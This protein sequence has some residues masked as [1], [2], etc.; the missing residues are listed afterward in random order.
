MKVTGSFAMKTLTSVTK[1]LKM[2]SRACLTGLLLT[3]TSLSVSAGTITGSKHDFSVSGFT[4]GEICIACH[5]P[6]NADATVS[7]A[8]LWNHAL[9]TATYSL[10]DSPTMDATDNNQQPTGTSKLCLSCHD[11]TVALDSSAD[12]ITMTGVAAVGADGLSNDHPISFTYNDILAT[13]DGALHNPATT[14]VTIGSGT[15]IKTGTIN[16]V[17]LI[18]GQI[19]C[20]TCHDVHNK[21]TVAT[22][23]PATSNKLLRVSNA[24]SGLCLTCH[25]K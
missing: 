19:Q 21:F 15:D 8:P 10:Y 18:G 7:E 5:T 12:G 16:D 22:V 24:G 13:A 20:A 23:A 14:T 2:T 17:M 3:I 4:G 6:H 11:G 9:S 25:N 1:D